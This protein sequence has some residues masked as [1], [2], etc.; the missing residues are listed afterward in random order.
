MLLSRN[1]K[2]KVRVVIKDVVCTQFRTQGCT[3]L[4]LRALRDP[5]LREPEG[6]TLTRSAGSEELSSRGLG[7]RVQTGD[8]RAGVSVQDVFCLA[9]TML[10]KFKIVANI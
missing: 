4:P 5:R 2:L 3:R 7:Q 10:P 8:S 6:N 1:Q 9:C